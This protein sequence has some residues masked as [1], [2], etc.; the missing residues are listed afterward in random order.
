MCIYVYIFLYK[1]FLILEKEVLQSEI[2][3][4]I[5]KSILRMRSESEVMGCVIT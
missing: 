4:G 1:L 3:S 2:Y 5:L